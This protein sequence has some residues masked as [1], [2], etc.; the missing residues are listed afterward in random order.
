MKKLKNNKLSFYTGKSG[1]I[2]QKQVNEV[3]EE[4][5]EI[6]SNYRKVKFQSHITSSD[7]V[8]EYGIGTGWNLDKINCKKKLGYDIAEHLKPSI[9][10]RNIKFV[11]NIETRI[12]LY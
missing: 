10:A 12:K 2:Y 8:L 1:I 7:T 5:F 4:A 9:E 11:S 3:T 6:I